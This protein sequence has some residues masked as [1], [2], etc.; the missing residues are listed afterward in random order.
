MKRGADVTDDIEKV[1]SEYFLT[2]YK[3]A[4][5]L[6]RDPQTAEEITQE[7]F[8]KAL[9]SINKF[10]GECKINVWLCQIAK[11]TYY[12]FCK[13]E[14]REIGIDDADLPELMTADIIFGIENKETV[15]EIHRILHDMNEPYKE[16]FSLRT[17]GELS[18]REIGELFGKSSNWAGVTYHRAKNKIREALEN[19]NIM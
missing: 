18:F 16:V 8:F 3:Y 19:E 9:K 5:S 4:L 11:N 2:V 15:Q 14:K 6:S 1:Y 13:K 10:K 7:T 17:F 12:S